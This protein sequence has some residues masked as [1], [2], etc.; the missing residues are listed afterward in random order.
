VHF[1]FRVA[2]ETVGGHITESRICVALPAADGAVGAIQRKELSV[3]KI[4]HFTCAVMAVEAGI[5]EVITV[6]LHEVCI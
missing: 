1:W 4:A 3:V 2:A 5:A 6:L